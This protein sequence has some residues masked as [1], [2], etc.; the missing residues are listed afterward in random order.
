MLPIITRKDLDY[1]DYLDELMFKSFYPALDII[2][3][4]EQMQ[5]NCN[6]LHFDENFDIKVTLIDLGYSNSI[7]ISG[8]E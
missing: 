7:S 2:F 8:L 4:C 5:V 1:D 3:T 6:Y